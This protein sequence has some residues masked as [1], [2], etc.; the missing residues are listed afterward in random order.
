[1][2]RGVR[3]PALA[4]VFAA[5]VVVSAQAPPPSPPPGQPPAQ[6][7]PAQQ[8]P[9]QQPPAPQPDP[10][11]PRPPVIR[12][13]VNF[14]SVDVIVTDNKGNPVEDLKQEDFE[15]FEDN[16]R[17]DVETFQIIKIDQ[18]TAALSS[19]LGEIR[20]TADEEREAARPDVRIFA[21]FL[22]DYHVRLGTSMGVR[23]PLM[24]FIEQQIAPGDLVGIMYPLLP[25]ADFSLTRNH[26]AIIQAI[27][28]FQGRKFNYEPRNQFEEQYA[29][30]PAATVEKVRNQVSM[31][32]LRG[33]AIKLGGYREGRK[34]IIYVSEGFTAQLPAQLND[35]VAAMPGMGNPARRMPGVEPTNPRAESI[36]FFNQAELL[37]DMREVY[38]AANRSNT[39][40]YA[41]DPRGLAAFE[42]D[43]NEGAGMQTDRKALQSSQDTLRVLAGETDGRAIVNRND[44]DAGLRQIV[45]DSSAYYL[46]GYNS[47]QAPTDGKFHAIKV[48][49]KRPGAQ[50]RARKGYWALTS[51]ETARVNN[52]KPEAPAAVTAALS[53][54]ASASRRDIVRTWI[55]TS[56]G[57]NGKTRVTLAW[58]PVTQA[59]GSA[60]ARE[61]PPSRLAVTAIAQTGE[62]YFRGRV[63]EPR[64]VTFDA[65]P[66]PMQVRFNIE[67][68]RGQVMDA[69]Q[70]EMT[71]PDFRKTEV[72]LSTPQFLRAR[73]AKEIA[74][75]K[76]DPAAVPTPDREFRRTERLAVRV[77]AYAATGDAPAVTAKLLNRT[78]NP[79]STLPVE[80]AG[81]AHLVDLPLASLAPGEY[82]IEIT[83]TSGKGSSQD[84]LAIRVIS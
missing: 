44:L 7:P 33:L 31:S 35:P 11:Q 49:V 59:A 22:D 72:S 65:D 51:E 4:A 69:A 17:Q 70:R 13:G 32:A 81:A 48:R 75:L 73:T 43:I 50:V 23:S 80:S 6:Q 19:P 84:V 57:E 29:Y 10:N 5:A 79:M 63:A 24:R 40:I 76:A 16:Q 38:D 18:S 64:V 15:V 12:R 9:A 39:A 55:G 45:R 20:S 1:M 30:Y 74:A 3:L 41:L 21:I 66:G 47:T 56:R 82:L 37:G 77:E 52:P 61:D 62:P 83:A 14:V 68:E 26:A 53:T 60:A 54:L 42:Y 67:N 34:S 2:R 28:N 25:V 46:L 58:E 36:E 8:P 78:G 71:V 27:Q